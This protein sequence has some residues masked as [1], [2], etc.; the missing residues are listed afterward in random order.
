MIENNFHW[1]YADKTNVKSW[2]SIFCQKIIFI[3]VLCK[4]KILLHWIVINILLNTSYF[5]SN[6]SL[7]LLE[8]SQK[9]R[10]WCRG[11]HTLK[12]N[13]T[14]VGHLQPTD[15]WDIEGG[16]LGLCSRVVQNQSTPLSIQH[17]T[18]IQ[19]ERPALCECSVPTHRFW[20]QVYQAVTTVVAD[21]TRWNYA[22][23]L[24]SSIFEASSCGLRLNIL[25]ASVRVSACAKYSPDAHANTLKKQATCANVS[26]VFIGW[27]KINLQANC[28]FTVPH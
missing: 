9:I 16:D 19:T 13:S 5:N 27:I 28:I 24:S 1:D 21:Y 3:L 23:W 8:K 18:W 7:Q 25:D 22:H 11:S 17:F 6:S 2:K 26:R 20:E 4:I 10:N 15:Y 12:F 14:F